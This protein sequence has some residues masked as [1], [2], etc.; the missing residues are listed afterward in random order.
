MWKSFDR[1]LSYGLVI[2]SYAFFPLTLYTAISFQLLLFFLYS[3]PHPHQ[4]IVFWSSPI[5]LVALQNRT[6]HSVQRNTRHRLAP[7]VPDVRV[8]FILSSLFLFIRMK[9]YLLRCFYTQNQT[10]D[11]EK[12]VYIFPLFHISIECIHSVAI[13]D[14][15]LCILAVLHLCVFERARF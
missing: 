9:L 14:N 6:L 3:S 12:A 2:F 5:I 1:L 4:W 10:S 11:F 15:G 7:S 8:C 13:A